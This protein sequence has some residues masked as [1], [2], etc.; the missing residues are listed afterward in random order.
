MNELGSLLKELRGEKSL[1]EV[2]KKS[3]ISHNYLSLLEKG[4]DPRTKAP[5]KP[6]PE[7]LKKLAE[8]YNYSY[9]ELLKVAGYLEDNPTETTEVYDY[10]EDPTI[11]PELM[12]LLDKLSSIP[13]K[14]REE[15]IKEATE[16]VEFLKS[17]GK[18]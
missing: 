3:G 11:S 18:I 5:I 13:E 4:I 16:Y 8:A 17:K 9:E 1:R 15:I 6:S 2:S 14:R 7:T 10:K 12:D